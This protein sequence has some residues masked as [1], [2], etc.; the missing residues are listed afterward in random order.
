MN[1]GA[2]VI[3][4]V[5]SIQ[6][7]SVLTDEDKRF[8]NFPSRLFER[9]KHNLAFVTRYNYHRRFHCATFSQYFFVAY[10]NFI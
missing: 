6:G 3:I 2:E 8:L 7:I 5:T 4:S 9:V 1:D 10:F